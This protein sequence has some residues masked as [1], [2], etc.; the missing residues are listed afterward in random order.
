[1]ADTTLIYSAML[2][3]MEQV[4]AVGKTGRNSAQ[5]YNFRGI[6]EV[7]NAV[8]P[9]LR[10]CSVIVVPR[11]LSMHHR[12][13]T[14]DKGKIQHEAIVEVEYSFIAEDG[15]RIVCSAPGEASDFSD[16]ATTQAMSVAYRTALIQA[17]C[18]PTDSP[19]PDES[20]VV[21]GQE[22]LSSWEEGG[23][24]DWVSRDRAWD[25]NVTLS[26][27]VPQGAAKEAL[28]DWFDGEG[29]SKDTMTVDQSVAWLRKIG[30]ATDVKEQTYTPSSLLDDPEAPF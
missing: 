18:L 21:R 19:D 8:G 4:Q 24:Q 17:L 1:M 20:G 11:V 30:E 27:E 25:D 15:S 3:V 6:D 23:W 9:A 22:T 2:D 26:K 7:V 10:K 12:D 29:F 13:F 28:M 16:K 14:T 5:G